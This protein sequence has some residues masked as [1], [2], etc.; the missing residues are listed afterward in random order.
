MSENVA[1]TVSGSYFE[2]CNCEAVCPCRSQGGRDGGRS[3]STYGSCDFVLSWVIRDGRAEGVVLDG[4]SVV[5]VGHSFDDAT[6]A[7]GQQLGEH[8]LDLGE[9]LLGRDDLGDLLG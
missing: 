9:G 4:L 6:L 2:A 5:M 1:W 8:D 3:T 7:T